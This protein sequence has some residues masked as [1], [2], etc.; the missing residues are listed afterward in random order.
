MWQQHQ[1]PLMQNMLS[2]KVDQTNPSI[3]TF[4]QTSS[5]ACTFDWKPRPVSENLC[6]QDLSY[7]WFDK[8]TNDDLAEKGGLKYTLATYYVCTY[9]RLSW[10]SEEGGRGGHWP[11]WI[12]KFD[13][14]L[15]TF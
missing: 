1:E 2:P 6:D 12:L 15:I 9:C 11:P 5:I 3:A 8:T 4:V 14:L 13:I 10:G 7:L